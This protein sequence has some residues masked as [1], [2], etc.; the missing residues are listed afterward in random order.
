MKI[1]A[2]VIIMLLILIFIVGG[3]WAEESNSYRKKTYFKVFIGLVILTWLGCLA[4]LGPWA[5]IH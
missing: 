4:F 3:L 1:I 2:W 5:L